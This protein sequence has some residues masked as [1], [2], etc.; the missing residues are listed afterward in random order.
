[1]DVRINYI[2]CGLTSGNKAIHWA[3]CADFQLNRRC[4]DDGVD[5][6]NLLKQASYTE[7]NLVWSY[8]S[9]FPVKPSL[10]VSFTV[11]VTEG[12]SWLHRNLLIILIAKFNLHDL[13][14]SWISTVVTRTNV[15][16]SYTLLFNNVAY[17]R[18]MLHHC[19]ARNYT[20]IQIYQNQSYVLIIMF[21]RN[22]LYRLKNGLWMITLYITL[23]TLQLYSQS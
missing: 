1:M 21:M 20:S 15:M 11:M 12:S 23:L 6:T 13:I 17:S 9:C 5:V 3:H 18:G 8:L 19:H 14:G 16:T 7:Y 22:I 4:T 10:F 2:L